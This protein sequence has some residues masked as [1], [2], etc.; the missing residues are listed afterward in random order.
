MLDQAGPQDTPGRQRTRGVRRDVRPSVYWPRE[1]YEICLRA[2]DDRGIP[3]SLWLRLAAAQAADVPPDPTDL[4][5]LR[6][7]EEKS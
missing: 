4:A 3:F 6:A 7:I 1:L 5:D 2:A